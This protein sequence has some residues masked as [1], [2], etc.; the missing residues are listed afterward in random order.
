MIMIRVFNERSSVD[1]ACWEIL[2]N[3]KLRPK[4]FWLLIWGMKLF[5]PPWYSIP[6]IFG[7]DPA[8]QQPGRPNLIPHK[9]GGFSTSVL[10]SSAYFLPLFVNWAELS[11]VWQQMLGGDT[12]CFYWTL[13]S[14]VWGWQY[15]TGHFSRG[16]RFSSRN[17]E[18]IKDRKIGW[19]RMSWKLFI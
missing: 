17:V 14:C 19:C 1:V 11:F 13:R 5:V 6:L 12:C 16:G 10:S 9:T 7:W 15:L 4:F 8:G 3:C 2:A 18:E